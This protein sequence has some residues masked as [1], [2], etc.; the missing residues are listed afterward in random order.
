MQIAI[1]ETIRG[2]AMSTLVKQNKLN[3]KGLEIE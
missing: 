3:H 1:L 2:L